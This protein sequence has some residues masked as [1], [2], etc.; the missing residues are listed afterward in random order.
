MAFVD[1]DDVFVLRRQ[2]QHVEVRIVLDALPQNFMEVGRHL[3]GDDCR[4]G[5]LAHARRS[6]QQSMIELL[7]VHLGRIDGDPHLIDYSALPDQVRKRAG[8]NV[9][10]FGG[11]VLF[12]VPLRWST[13]RLPRCNESRG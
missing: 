1:V 5:T 2:Q 7:V 10:D 11:F 12:H 9:V 13:T 8:G 4:Q 3:L 6:D